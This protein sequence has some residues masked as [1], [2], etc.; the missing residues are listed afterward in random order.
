ACRSATAPA[1]IAY[2]FTPSRIAFCAASLISSGPSKSGNP[3]P[4]FT[5]PCFAAS[6]ENSE[7]TVVGKPATRRANGSLATARLVLARVAHVVLR[8]LQK[9]RALLVVDRPPDLG[10]ASDD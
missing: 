7:N 10:R 2:W 3:C 4:R 1:P 9:P 8:R 5:A 6:A